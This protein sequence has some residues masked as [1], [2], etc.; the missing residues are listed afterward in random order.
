MGGF[1]FPPHRVLS[2]QRYFVSGF[3]GLAVFV[4]STIATEILYLRLFFGRFGCVFTAGK[5]RVSSK[6]KGGH[7][8]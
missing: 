6:R 3:A 7:F 2:Q 5:V 4:F 8:H 1:I